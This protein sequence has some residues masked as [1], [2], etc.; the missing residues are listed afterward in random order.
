MN[1]ERSVDTSASPEAVWRIWS[2]P[3]RWNEWNPSVKSMTLEGPF[4]VGTKAMMETPR[5]THQ[6]TVTALE[7][8][9]SFTLEG[10][11][12]PGMTM[13]FNCKIEPRSSGSRIS[14]SITLRGPLAGIFGNMMGK[15]M[16]DHI[17]PIL[18]A[19]ATK[20]EQG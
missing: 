10:S 18:Q 1:L 8:G 7:P 20:A 3:E 6:V 14:Q 16:V 13:L 17:P 15:Q 5:G 4:A 11:G 19:L 12:M 2:D 9:R